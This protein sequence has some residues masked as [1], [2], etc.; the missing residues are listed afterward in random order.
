MT[1]PRASAPKRESARTRRRLIRVVKLSSYPPGIGGGEKQTHA[2]AKTMRR[3]GM[4][5]RVVDTRGDG[6]ARCTRVDGV[7]VLRYETPGYPVIDLFSQRL[8]LGALL[9][10]LESRCDILQVN[11]LGPALFA[12]LATR[13]RAGIPVVLV[14]WGSCRPGV[15]PFRR[16]PHWALLRSFAR[17]ADRIIALSR[18]M[19]DTLRE[20]WRFP[21]DRIEVIPNGVDLERFRPRPG[22]V[23][24]AEIPSAGAVVISV[25]RLTAAKRYDLLIRAWAQVAARHAGARLVLLGDGVLGS[26]LAALAREEGI[27]DRVLFPG[28]RTDVERW[29][30]AADLY[31][32][33]SDTEG[34]SNAVLEAMASGLPAVATRVS[35]SEDLIENGETGVLVL[36]GDLEAMRDALL[37]LLA[38]PEER[39]RMGSAGRARAARLFSLSSVATAYRDTYERLLRERENA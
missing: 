24:P 36:P 2:V 29:L 26:Q 27:A 18:S 35:G 9:R 34:M 20:T 12:A 5:V 7:P 14:L 13:R 21:A 22:A 10:R 11:H 6:G 30:A 16:A 38:R 19:A 25:G 31:V 1:A 15:G 3:Q 8:K 37:G 33:S 23:R 39:L 28:A 32:S 4:Q 17:G